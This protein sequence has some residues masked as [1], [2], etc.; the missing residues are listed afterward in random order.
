MRA[1]EL[2]YYLGAL[3]SESNITDLG[4]LMAQLP[5]DPQ[6]SGSASDSPLHPGSANL[7]FPLIVRETSDRKSEVWVQ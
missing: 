5:L 2:L 1:L 7:T 3:D 4:M 6:V